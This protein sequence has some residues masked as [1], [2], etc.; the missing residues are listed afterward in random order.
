M[1]KS[2]T[3]HHK[4]LLLAFLLLYFFAGR[5]AEFG[6]ENLFFQGYPISKPVIRIALDLNLDDIRVRSSAGMKIYQ[7]SGAYKLLAEDAAEA[8]VRGRQDKLSEKFLVQTGQ[9]RKREDADAAL[10]ALREK[11]SQRVVVTQ[12]GDPGGENIFQVRAGDFLTRGDALAF[13]KK[14]N[15]LGIR[16]AWIIREEVSAVENHPRWITINDQLINLSADASLYF[17]PAATESYLSYRGRNY[18]GIF[19]LRGSRKGLILVN[20]LNVEEYLKGVVPGELPPS[21]FNE[22]EAQKAQAIAA[23]TYAM[24]NRGQYNDLGFDLLATPAS[25]VYL[26][27]SAESP[28][29]SRAVEETRGEVAVYGGQLINALYMSTCGGATEDVEAMFEGGPMPYLKST[30]CLDE[31]DAAWTVKSPLVFPSVQVNGH[32]VSPQLAYLA[33]LDV[34]S[35][36]IAAEAWREPAESAEVLGWA[37]RAAAL[38]GKKADKAE[39]DSALLAFPGLARI[40]SDAF[41]WKDRV[42]N[43]MLK[44][45][46]ERILYGVT[47]LKPEERGPLAY[48]IVSGIYPASENLADRNRRPTKAEAAYYLYKVLASY[49][50]FSGQGSI[51]GLKGGRLTVHTDGADKELE[52]TP[53]V[54]LLRE[55]EGSAAPTS[56]LDLEA[57]DV[58]KWIESEGKIRLLQI[59][60][61]PVGNVLDYTS[62]FHRWQTRI[63]RDD[64]EARLNQYYPIGRLID[65]V[66]GKRG[67]SRRVLEM[68]IVGQESQV[69][70]RGLKIRQVL[71]L[72]DNLFVVDRQLAPDG[73]VGVFVF[74]GKGWGHGV[75]LCQ[76]G[77]F[78]MAQ[79]GASYEEILKKYYRGI[80]L[81]KMD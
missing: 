50:D 1:P 6:E 59:V 64:L 74:S 65:I 43:L 27:L 69:Q 75:G 58:V 61:A 78:R 42:N 18:R 55:L 11:V 48:F 37:R 62:Q 67:A 71:N 3:R 30:E 68:T 29:S 9:F 4:Y 52:L 46:A 54:L 36:E 17:I 38:L 63:S 81:Q 39:A 44:A 32:T 28:L 70:V 79:K 80:S 49:K 57:G 73:R 7:V 10:K 56:W 53:A 8:N 15:V 26:G 31:R 40:L 35:P 5:P 41:D 12:D 23:R 45:E 25:Q 34:L 51:H 2:I 16:E 22:I 21:F 72:R 60:S 77:A 76:V 13:I 14:I 19:V 33:A 47:G 24:K 66:P 20:I